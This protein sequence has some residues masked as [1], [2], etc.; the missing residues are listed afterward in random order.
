MQTNN[1][2]KYYEI[3]ILLI[4]YFIILI[5]T[6]GIR[7]NII[8]NTLPD[9]IVTTAR[10]TGNVS[11][12]VSSLFSIFFILLILFLFSFV[13]IVFDFQTKFDLIIESIVNLII[14]FCV[15]EL[16]RF[17]LTL[18]EFNGSFLSNLNYK[19]DLMKQLQQTT[20][21]SYDKIFQYITLVF[22]GITFS[23]SLFLKSKFHKE[24]IVFSVIIFLCISITSINFLDLFENYL[25]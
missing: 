18:Y 8:L 2:N 13:I 1:Q 3:G 25:R 14:V 12:V 24:T 17:S 11:L 22:G 16:L 21:Y 15:L 9:F 19:E 4:I 10:I 20:W 23:I 7:I 6:S 5:F